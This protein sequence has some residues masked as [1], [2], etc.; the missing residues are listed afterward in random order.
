[1]NSMFERMVKRTWPSAYWSAMSQ[2]L[3]TVPTSIWRWVPA[4]TDQTSSPLWATW[5]STPGR[6]RSWYRQSP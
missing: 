5:C 3:R 2:S 6:G 4:R 1:M